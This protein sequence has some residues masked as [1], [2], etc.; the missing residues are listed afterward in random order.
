MQIASI[1]LLK[2]IVGGLLLS[3]I[4]ANANDFTHVDYTTAP[5]LVKVM[6]QIIL[7]KFATFSWLEILTSYSSFFPAPDIIKINRKDQ[8]EE[9]RG[10]LSYLGILTQYPLIWV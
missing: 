6:L 3:S 10:S 1:V 9:S 2:V 4:T 5:E 7:T 8:E